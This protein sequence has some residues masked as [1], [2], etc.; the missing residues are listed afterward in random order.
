[1]ILNRMWLRFV[2]FAKL[3]TS[4]EQTEHV[5]EAREGAV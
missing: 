4:S 2:A 3:R 5:G 1:M